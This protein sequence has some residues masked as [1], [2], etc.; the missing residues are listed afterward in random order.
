MPTSAHL[1]YLQLSTRV[2][3]RCTSLARV[4]GAR[5]LLATQVP[6]A[7][8]PNETEPCEVSYTSPP[9]LQEGKPS[10]R[11]RVIRL[12]EGMTMME[13]TRALETT[14]SVCVLVESWWGSGCV[15]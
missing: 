12:Q 3:A 1:M 8:L 2:L 14:Q 11:K 13:L 10:H 9:V 4:G 15:T 5:R 7:S 6:R